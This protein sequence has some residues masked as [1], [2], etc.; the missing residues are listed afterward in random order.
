[1]RARKSL[2][3][4]ELSGTEP[5]YVDAAAPPFRRSK[6]KM[7]DDL[8]PAAETEWKRL[9]KELSKRGTLTRVDSSMLEVYVRMWSRWKKVAALAEENPVTDVSW[10]D[11]ND[12][13]HFKTIE[14]PASAMASRL[15]NSLRNMLK[16]LSAT[17]ASRERTR[18]LKQQPSKNAPPPPLPDGYFP[19]RDE[20]TLP[21]PEPEIDLSTIEES[22]VIQ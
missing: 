8:S 19:P 14:H 21:E 4:H 7:P 3:E 6:P 18:P 22:K 17:P 1:M 11:K 20:T 2:A 12:T 9:V 5:Q 10:I 16:E 15:E 13:E